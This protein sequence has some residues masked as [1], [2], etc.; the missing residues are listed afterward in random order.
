MSK[1]FEQLNSDWRN[2]SI[3]QLST[4]NNL[5]LTISTGF[6]VYVLQNK[7]ISDL[8]CN[9]K[10]SIDY[11]KL[12]FLMSLIFL[13]FS[14]FYGFATI[15][16]RLY[17]FRITRN[18]IFAR[19]RTKNK[20]KYTDYNSFKPYERTKALFTILFIRIQFITRKDTKKG[21]EDAEFKQKFETLVKLSKILGVTTWLYTKFQVLHFILSFILYGIFKYTTS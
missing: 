3:N 8:H 16:T 2:I 13:F 17:D 18:I 15:F 21:F 7:S 9:V 1:N 10:E 20:L 4:T 11:T 12:Y 14:I 6:F 19:S 5:L